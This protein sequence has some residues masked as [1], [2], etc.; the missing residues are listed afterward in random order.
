[1]LFRYWYQRHYFAK[2]L[3]EQTQSETCIVA[4]VTQNRLNIECIVNMEKKTIRSLSI[5]H[6]I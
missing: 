1:M 3:M 5:I 4:R 2:V 6:Q